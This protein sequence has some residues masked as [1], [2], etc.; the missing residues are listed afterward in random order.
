M[1][2]KDR[3]FENDIVYIRERFQ[4]K[5]TIV[6]IIAEDDVYIEVAKREIQK[7]RSKIEG[8][9][10][11]DDFFE[12]TFEPYTCPK[13]AP[14]IIKKMCKSSEKLNVGPM[15]TVAG[16]IAECIIKAMTAKGAK[17]AVVDNGGDIAL[18]SDKKVNVGIYT[19]NQSTEHLAFQ[20]LPENKII[21]ICTSSGRIGHSVSFGDTDAVTVISHDVSLADAAATALGNLVN[22]DKDIK[23][24]FKILDGIEKIIG[25]MIVIDNKIGLWGE[26]PQ[27]IQ[28]KVP[29]KLITR[30]W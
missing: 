25:A 13:D 7:C 28:A 16:I 10:R 24:A 2:N 3:I 18:F 9:I 23:G 29:Y 11:K 8:Y 20:V 12:V 5:E 30:G 21:G 27:I 22:A 4:L 26:V 6:T 19:G 17:H 15:S 14:E 1:S